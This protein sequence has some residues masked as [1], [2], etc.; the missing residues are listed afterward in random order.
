ME[1]TILRLFQ[2]LDSPWSTQSHAASHA[3]VLSSRCRPSSLLRSVGPQSSV[4]DFP[5][6]Q[7]PGTIAATML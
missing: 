6:S 1:Q 7:D 2:V 3:S 4:V 5:T